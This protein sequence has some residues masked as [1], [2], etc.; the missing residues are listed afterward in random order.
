VLRPG[1]T[2]EWSLAYDPAANDGRGSITATLGD[3][4]V[5]LDL[6]QG[7]R[8]KA[9][10]ARFDRFGLFS[11]GPGGQIVK[12]YLDDLEYTDCSVEL[13]P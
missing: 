3:E 5:T 9:Q 13:V 8:L 12:L 4:T 1:Q 7:Q 11:I 6:R 10:A 2:Y